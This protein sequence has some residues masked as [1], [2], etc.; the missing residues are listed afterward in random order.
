MC[1]SHFSWK[2]VFWASTDI[3]DIDPQKVQ[4]VQ[5]WL[6]EATSSFVNAKVADHVLAWAQITMKTAVYKNLEEA[7][8]HFQNYGDVP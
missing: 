4:T 3:Y 7:D 8:K 6:A 1:D 2:N 5:S